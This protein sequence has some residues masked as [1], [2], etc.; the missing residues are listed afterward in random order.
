MSEQSPEQAAIDS[1]VRFA[2][3][4]TTE[5]RELV[6][7]D[8]HGGWEKAWQANVTPW[9]VG[10]I[11]PPLQEVIESQELSSKLVSNGRALVPGA[12]R[13]YDAIFLAKTLGYQTTAID[14]SP[15]AIAH[16]KELVEASA[17]SSQ[18]TLVETD[19]FTYK[20]PEY[21][22]YDLAYDY[23]FF[24]AITPDRR[25]AW[26]SQMNELIKSG[27]YLITL[28]WPMPI[29]GHKDDIGP[30]YQIEVQDYAKVLG[31]D[32]EK[33]IDKVPEM[34]SDERHKGN[35]KIVV[36]KKL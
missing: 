16:A 3:N 1:R 4:S 7:K 2:R 13:A 11:Q 12:G 14:I 10:K 36:W 8:P 22:R 25:P 5:F 29:G 17:S 26:G 30:P 31:D 24:V 18:V 15:T 23:T 6:N 28:V 9:D 21:E 34:S 35:Q 20:V 32:W 33:I 27:G 19:F